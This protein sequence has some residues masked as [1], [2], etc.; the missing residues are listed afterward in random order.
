MIQCYF[1]VFTALI[2]L[3]INPRLQRQDW[4]WTI[5][6]M[7]M[8]SSIN[9]ILY[10]WRVRKLRNAVLGMWDSFYANKQRKTNLFFVDINY[11][12]YL[13]SWFA[14]SGVIAV[15]LCENK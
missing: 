15:T 2:L 8:N 9:L 7:Y 4:N 13:F 10:C 5:Y 12:I 11:S 3:T 6:V 14:V 1:P